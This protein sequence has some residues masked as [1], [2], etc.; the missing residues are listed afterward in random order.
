MT[1]LKVIGVMSEFVPLREGSE[2]FFLQFNSGY[3][4]VE[5]MDAILD[6]AQ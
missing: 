2:D 6:L 4:I 3:S 1:R 5:P